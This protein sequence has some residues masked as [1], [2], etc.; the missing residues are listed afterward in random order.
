MLKWSLLLEGLGLYVLKESRRAYAANHVLISGNH[1]GS[2]G[3]GH[4]A[5]G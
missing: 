1:D 5:R 3:P 4:G 2:I